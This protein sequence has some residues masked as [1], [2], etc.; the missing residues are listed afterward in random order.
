MNTRLPFY[1]MA[2]G[3]LFFIAG[4]SKP[5]KDDFFHIKYEII[6]TEEISDPYPT[7]I[8]TGGIA[9]GTFTN[10][11]SGKRW[12]HTTDFET[13]FRP[14]EV[15]LNGQNMRLKNAGKVTLNIYVNNGLKATSTRETA[16]FEG[17]HTVTTG[18]VGYVIN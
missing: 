15:F 7:I 6:T 8:T 9:G 11:T 3:L 1:A 2:I 17:K 13:S 4:C 10:F 14:V 5:R 16:I 18:P 12:E